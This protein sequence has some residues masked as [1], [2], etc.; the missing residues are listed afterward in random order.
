MT[1]I[2]D[3][4]TVAHAIFMFVASY[5]FLTV[6]FALPIILWWMLS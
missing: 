2:K 6:L 5:M 1:I 4:A 3:A